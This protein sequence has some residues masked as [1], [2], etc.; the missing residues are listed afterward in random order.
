[1]DRRELLKQSCGMGVCACAAAVLPESLAM[2]ADESES[3]ER[4]LQ[5][6]Q[7]WD[8]HTKRQLVKLWELLEPHLDDQTRADIIEQLGRNCAKSI[9]WAQQCKGDPEAFFQRMKDSQNEDIEFDREK[10]I[11]TIVSPERPCVCSLVDGEKTPPYFCQCS[12]GWQ[13][14]TYETILGKK[15]D[16]T[17]VE[18]CLRGSKRCVFK[19]KILS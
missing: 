19:V 18:S 8:K 14:E 1:M 16:C 15:V 17:V 3:P 7:W 6:L 12:V 4:Q 11:I 5:R 10:G 9:G 2:A 13:K